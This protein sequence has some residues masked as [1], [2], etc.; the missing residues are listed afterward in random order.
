MAELSDA[1]QRQSLGRQTEGASFPAAP[2][3][4]SMPGR[5]PDL[6]E[7]VSGH[8]ATGRPRAISA[9]NREMLASDRQR[10]PGPSAARGI[11]H[12]S[13]RSVGR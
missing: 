10:H 3:A 12:Q 4:Q 5:Y 7:S 9:A 8:I 11:W 13:H 1:E 2:T 6:L